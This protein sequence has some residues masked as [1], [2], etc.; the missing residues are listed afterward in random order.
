MPTTCSAV[1]T[2]MRVRDSTVGTSTNCSASCGS[3]IGECDGHGEQEILGT[4]ITC[5]GTKESRSVRHDNSWS[6]PSAARSGP[7]CAAEPC[8]PRSAARAPS[9]RSPAAFHLSSLSSVP[10]GRRAYQAPHHGCDAGPQRA[11]SLPSSAR[12]ATTSGDVAPSSS[13]RKRSQRSQLPSTARVKQ[14]AT[15]GNGY[16]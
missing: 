3:R 16:S 10:V 5:S 15:R 2:A 11:P 13:L 8:P 4:S 12:I 14:Q 6:T 1:C 9:G 7:L